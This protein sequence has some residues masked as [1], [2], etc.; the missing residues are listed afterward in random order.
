MEVFQPNISV[1]RERA[2]C[3][4]MFN[5]CIFFLRVSIDG[6]KH[7]I[8]G[9]Q[10]TQQ[11]AAQTYQ[12]SVSKTRQYKGTKA[13]PHLLLHPSGNTNESSYSYRRGPKYCQ[14]DPPW[15]IFK[16]LQTSALDQ[17][18]HKHGGEQFYRRK[19][20]KCLNNIWNKINWENMQKVWEVSWVTFYFR[21]TSILEAEVC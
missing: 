1:S 19:F 9:G 17:V 5:S 7:A 6:S 11:Q 8:L 21:E 13:G 12:T 20:F 14:Q 15:C 2:V 18:S 16:E 4:L 10:A 3:E